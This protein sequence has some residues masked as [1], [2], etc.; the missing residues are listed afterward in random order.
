MAAAAGAPADATCSR[1]F[2]AAA[3]M[4]FAML[5]FFSTSGAAA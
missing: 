1:P 2:G 3:S 4:L 5:G